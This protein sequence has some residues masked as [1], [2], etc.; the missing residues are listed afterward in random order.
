MNSKL[1]PNTLYLRR[2]VP[3]A[4]LIAWGYTHW[5]GAPINP[6]EDYRADVLPCAPL[7][8]VAL[9]PAH[10]VTIH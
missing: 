10:A 3:G 7:A 2:R 6:V 9:R 8:V 5:K 1:P 4:T